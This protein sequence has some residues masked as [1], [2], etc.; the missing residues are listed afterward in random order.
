MF[1]HLPPS[2]PP[3]TSLQRIPELTFFF[4]WGTDTGQIT[5]RKQG[6]ASWPGA[7]QW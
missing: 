4:Y 3:L 7:G 6:E 1:S 2:P 5:E